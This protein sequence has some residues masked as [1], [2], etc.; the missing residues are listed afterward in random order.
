ML[1]PFDYGVAI[2]SFCAEMYVVVWLLV[3]NKG[4]R[5][6][7][8]GIYMLAVV[9][10]TASQYFFL[11]K[12]GFN[13]PQYFYTYYYSDALLTIALFFV[14]MSFYHQVFQ[15]MGVSKYV[16]GASILLLSATALF[17]YLVVRQNTSHLTS[18][19]VVEMGQNLY[20]VGVV[21][22]YLLWGAIL[23]LRETRTRLIQLV[24]AL[25][26]FFSADAAAYALRNM[27]PDFQGAFLKFIPPLLGAFLPLA[28]AY[29]FTKIPEEARL[30]T[31]RLAPSHQ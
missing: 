29:T 16:R 2:L 15:Q 8:L 23:K 4:L 19:F 5:Y 10:G 9:L 24:L 30:L 14:I 21:L 3:S 11:H 31:A 22:T 20:F 1:G 26:I 27:F 18:R 12:F 6:L 28:W 7:S 13:S 17:S 25:G